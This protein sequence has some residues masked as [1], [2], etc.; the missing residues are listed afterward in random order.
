MIAA[1]VRLNHHHSDAFVNLSC[2]I[3]LS[4]YKRNA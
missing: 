3:P 1:T 2:S 4:D